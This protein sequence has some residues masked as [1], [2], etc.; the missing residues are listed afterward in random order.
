MSKQ[1]IRDMNSEDPHRWVPPPLDWAPPF[2]DETP[3][4]KP[5]SAG[6]A[7]TVAIIMALGVMGYIMLVTGGVPL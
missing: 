6:M 5:V 7:A 2:E 3:K 1:H 4:K